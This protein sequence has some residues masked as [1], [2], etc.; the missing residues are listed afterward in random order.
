MEKDNSVLVTLKT[1]NI[2]NVISMV[3]TGFEEICHT[4]IKSWRKPWL[5]I[6]KMTEENALLFTDTVWMTV[7]EAYSG[8]HK[9]IVP[10]FKNFEERYTK[11][12]INED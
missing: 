8:I 7:I 11:K 9:K 12:Q 6:E 3:A 1:I 2:K 10:E 5:G 4:I